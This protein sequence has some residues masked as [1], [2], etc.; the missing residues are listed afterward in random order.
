MRS[1]W[2]EGIRVE[3]N[4]NQ[5]RVQEIMQFI[6]YSDFFRG[7]GGSRLALLYRIRNAVRDPRHQPYRGDPDGD[8]DAQAQALA[9]D[10]PAIALRLDSLPNMKEIR[11]S[12]ASVSGE[13]SLTER[14]VGNFLEGE[15]FRYAATML[16]R[17]HKRSRNFF[18]LLMSH[19]ASLAVAFHLR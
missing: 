4:A 17:H 1:W 8:E 16:Y 5:V 18:T 12:L 13:F 14:F 7:V 15:A 10:E 19:W 3:G 9:H 2:P 11:E 6:D